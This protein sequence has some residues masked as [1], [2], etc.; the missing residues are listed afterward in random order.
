LQSGKTIDAGHDLDGQRL[1]YLFSRV[2]DLMVDDS[3]VNYFSVPSL[4]N[5]PSI[6]NRVIVE[7]R[8]DDEGGGT[9]K[10]LKE[11]SASSCTHIVQARNALQRLLSGDPAATDPHVSSGVEGKAFSQP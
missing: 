1:T 9:W 10:C 11:P 4:G 3:F 8:G 5:R 2:E 7:H 6:K